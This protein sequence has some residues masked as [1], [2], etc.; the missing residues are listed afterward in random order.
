M[1]LAVGGS[2]WPCNLNILQH[3]VSNIQC[4]QRNLGIKSLRIYLFNMLDDFVEQRSATSWMNEGQQQWVH[5]TRSPVDLQQEMNVTGRL[6][7]AAS[8]ENTA[9]IPYGIVYI[10]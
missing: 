1:D 4:Q 6:P 7:H 10:L 9:Q 3:P 8:S 2:A 5:T